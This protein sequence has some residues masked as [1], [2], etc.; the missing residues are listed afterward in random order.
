MSKL[1]SDYELMHFGVKGMKWG[2][3]KKEDEPNKKPKKAKYDYDD[4]KVVVKKGST[5]RRV[6]PGT[7]AEQEKGYKGHAYTSHTE[8]DGKSYRDLTDMLSLGGKNNFVEMSF[9]AKEKIV[10]PSKKRRVDA[11]VELINSDPAVKQSFK[12]ATRNPLNYLSK[13]TIDTLDTDKKVDKAY[14]RFSYLLVCK[15]E[16]RDAYFNKLKK[17]GYNAVV[18]DADAGVISDEPLIIFHREKTL[19]FDKINKIGD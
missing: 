12:K 13:K 11:F 9:K 19:K 3:R 4:K 2:H 10:S 8:A 7:N 15:P 5:I 1:I 18:D 6:V 17:E 16:L 14:N